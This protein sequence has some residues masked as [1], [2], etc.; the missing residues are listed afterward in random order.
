MLAALLL[1][2]IQ[3]FHGT[4]YSIHQ[5]AADEWLRV[6]EELTKFRTLEDKEDAVL[7]AVREVVAAAPELEAVTEAQQVISDSGMTPD[8]ISFLRL[9]I[10]EIDIIMLAYFTLKLRRE[11]DDIAAMLALGIL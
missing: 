1:N 4:S 3:L 8:E 6:Q 2:N 7:E 11:D 10:I 9:K 5:Q